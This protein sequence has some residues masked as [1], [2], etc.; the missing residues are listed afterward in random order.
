MRQII[1]SLALMAA[2]VLAVFPAGAQQEPYVIGQITLEAT[3]ISAGLGYTWGGG[4]LTF[5]GKQY[6]FTVKG[7][8]IVAVGISTIKATGDVYN[9]KTAADLAGNYAV[10]TAGAALIKGPAGLVMRNE[11]GVVINLKASQT[12]VQFSLGAEGLIISMKK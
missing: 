1:A 10:A 9:M 2:F 3:Q 7:L 11:K 6:P 4:T 12:G 5:E 8:N